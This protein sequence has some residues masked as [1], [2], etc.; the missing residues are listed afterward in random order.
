MRLVTFLHNGK[1][2]VGL[3]DE[4]LSNVSPLPANVAPPLDMSVS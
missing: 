2:A 1:Q 4:T 3:A